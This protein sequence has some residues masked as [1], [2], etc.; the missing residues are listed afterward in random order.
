MARFKDGQKPGPGRPKGAPNKA[1]QTLRELL[2]E[3]EGGVPGP[4]AL[5]KY[6]KEA[7]Q[8]GYS[9]QRIIEVNGEEVPVEQPDAGLVAAGMSAMGKALGYAYPSL[10]AIEHSGSVSTQPVLE[11]VLAPDPAP[12]AK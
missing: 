4:I 2:E 9:A 8:K 11:V 3:V 5:W 1:T 7:V 12:P 6:G 10:K